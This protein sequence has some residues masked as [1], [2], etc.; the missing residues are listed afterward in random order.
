M[1]SRRNFFT[2]TILMAT[3]L[4][5]C[6]CINNLKD[7]WNDYAVNQ[8]TETAENYPSKINMYLPGEGEEDSVG[9]DRE[10]AAEGETIVA[11]NKIVCI[12]AET[13]QRVQ[14]A[15]EWAT[16]TKR[17]FAEYASLSSLGDAK[18]DVE[19]LVIDPDCVDWESVK[20]IDSLFRY[21]ENGTHLVFWNLP[22]ASVIKSD[23]QVREL[24]GIRKVQEEE[25]TVTGL[26]LREGF[27]LGGEVFYLEKE[28]PGGDVPLPGSEEFPGAR[29]FPWYLPASGTKVYMK[30]IPEDPSVKAEDY[31]IVMWRKSFGTAYVFAVN[32]DF[33]EGL[34][35]MGILSAMS[36]EMHSYEIYPVLNAKNIIL[37]GY[38]SLADE[39]AAEMER[40]YSRSVKQ[41]FQE[42][43]WPNISAV[44]EK[45]GFRATCLMTPQ[46]D[47]T[48][49]NLP[50]GKQLE[51]Y[52]KI[53]H[54]KFAEVGL[55]GLSVSDT[56]L[57]EKLREDQA[58]FQDVLGGYEATS[59]YTGEIAEEEI[60]EAL[61]E[62]MLASVRTVVRGFDETETMGFLTDNVTSQRV[63]GDG[64]KYTYKN[65]FLVK[66][67]GTALG[68]FSMS[69][70]LSRV[71]YPE[72]DEDAWEELSKALGTTIG[73]YG[74][75]FQAFDGTTASECDLRIRQ[76]LA[77]DYSHSRTDDR[78][79]LE[80]E[81][82][83][84]PVWFL[85]RTHNE[86][87]REIEGGSW[88]ELEKDA[89][90]IEVRESQVTLTLEPADERFYD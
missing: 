36:V 83:T 54:E 80:V 30:G 29:T 42:L 66:S 25:T 59:F 9:Q 2:I 63:L 23:S 47:Y 90:L 12:G 26:Y 51:Y 49:D 45:N 8:Y 74:K 33:M 60:E 70:D 4:F 75:E 10:E 14:T 62:E 44:L 58:F 56:S 88:Q 68:Y 11:R 87:I 61:Q 86:A 39:N 77:L 20:E 5:L 7:S 22:E 41:V 55:W 32:G 34:Q 21:V 40:I 79:R 81:G 17:G 82:A 27:L 38:P 53:F 6:M 76:F 52:L 43:L 31:P 50:D 85:L 67:I 71:A 16:Y 19:M 89:Y 78:V 72:E 1:I 13:D 24:L 64:L 28:S 69:F 73:T 84:E 15:K 57:V 65:N 37:A 18:A 35:G 48:D 3:V 46:Y